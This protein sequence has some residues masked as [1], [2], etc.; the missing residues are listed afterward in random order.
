MTD[1]KGLAAIEFIEIVANLGETD[2]MMLGT[3]AFGDHLGLTLLAIG[4]M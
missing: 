4:A 3:L 1:R 2:E